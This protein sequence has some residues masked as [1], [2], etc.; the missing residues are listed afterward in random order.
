MKRFSFIYITILLAALVLKGCGVEEPAETDSKS[1]VVDSTSSSSTDNSTT[2]TA[3]TQTFVDPGFCR[4]TTNTSSRDSSLI[5][6]KKESN[7]RS[8][9]K[10]GRVLYVDK[11]ALS[12]YQTDYYLLLDQY[13]LDSEYV[14]GLDAVHLT[15]D[16]PNFGNQFRYGFGGKRITVKKPES[17][18]FE[19]WHHIATVFDGTNYKLFLDGVELKN[20]T[21]F[22]GLIPP[23]QVTLIGSNLVNRSLNPWIGKVDEVRIRSAK[24]PRLIT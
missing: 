21:L 1:P 3:S 20:S 9:K 8:S 15:N 5:V 2:G 14:G 17:I 24:G 4:L 6:N 7:T 13:E 16:I 18:N 22:P 10:T 19:N 12:Q 23:E 11:S